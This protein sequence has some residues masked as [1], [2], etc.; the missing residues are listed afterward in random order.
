[1]GIDIMILIVDYFEAFG[2]RIE[3]SKKEEHNY[4]YFLY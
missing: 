1:M 2:G 4:Y 3:A